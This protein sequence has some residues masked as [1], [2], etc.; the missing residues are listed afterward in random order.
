MALSVL[1]GVANFEIKIGD[2]LK[3]QITETDDMVETVNDICTYW[4]VVDHLL[5]DSAMHQKLLFISSNDKQ[6]DCRSFKDELIFNQ[7]DE[8]ISNPN[9]IWTV[10]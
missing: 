1:N 10:L 2:I 5:Y 7:R 4:L 9:C 8:F 3:C 6:Y